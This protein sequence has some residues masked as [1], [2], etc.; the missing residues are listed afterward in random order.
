MQTINGSATSIALAFT[1][2]L[3]GSVQANVIDNGDMESWNTP[4]NAEFWLD[5]GSTQQVAGRVSGYA[6]E[7]ANQSGAVTQNFDA[8]DSVS[9]DFVYTLDFKQ[10]SGSST[11][12]SMNVS[13]RD[14]GTVLLNIAVA[15]GP[16]ADTL[17]AYNGSWQQLGNIG[18]VADDTWYRLTVTGTLD[19]GG[20]YD[21]TLYDLDGDTQVFTLEDVAYWQAAPTS[22]SAFR[23]IS[24]EPQSTPWTLDNISLE[25]AAVPEPATMTLLG[26]GGLCLLIRYR[27]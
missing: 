19:A 1:V 7:L 15:S 10:S 21:V 9:G 25:S 26:V 23:Y 16:E 14:G 20:S 11:D 22:S 4:T 5:N 6:M 27:K 18:D 3:A 24:V 8:S 12:R 17:Y 13:L 2:L